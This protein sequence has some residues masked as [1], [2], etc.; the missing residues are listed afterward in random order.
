MMNV[1]TPLKLAKEE[2][3]QPQA[4]PGTGADRA[5]AAGGDGGQA[6]REGAKEIR[7]IN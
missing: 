3:K 6:A 5:S 7:L 4:R 1:T 2:A